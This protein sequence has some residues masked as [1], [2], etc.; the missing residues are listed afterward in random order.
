G[1]FVDTYPVSYIDAKNGT[2]TM[3]QIAPPAGTT[4]TD[5]PEGTSPQ[6]GSGSGEQGNSGDTSNDSGNNGGD[7][8]N[9]DGTEGNGEPSALAPQTGSTSVTS[10]EFA[11]KYTNH[12]GKGKDLNKK[13]RVKSLRL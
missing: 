7:S 5:T 6:N 2:V 8:I 13:K 12:P 4:P 10:G 11:V 9:Q 1:K 3:P